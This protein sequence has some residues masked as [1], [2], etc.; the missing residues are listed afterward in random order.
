MG[1]WFAQSTATPH[2]AILDNRPW[3][4]IQEKMA[5]LDWPSS[6]GY[7]GLRLFMM[8]HAERGNPISPAS[9]V[10]HLA[11]I[12]AADPL[13]SED[14]MYKSMA[15]AGFPDKLTSRWR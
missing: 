8:I 13:V 10:A 1:R 12:L 3:P 2:E 5:T 7:Y 11:E 6:P 4:R 9:A 14:A 15:N